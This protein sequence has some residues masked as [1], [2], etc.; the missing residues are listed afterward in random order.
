[1]SGEIDGKG[2][3][4]NAKVLDMT[5]TSTIIDLGNDRMM[6]R[7]KGIYDARDKIKRRVIDK[8]PI[9]DRS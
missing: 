6:D 5:E 9:E 1:M 2:K 3:K 7:V 8:S 4:M